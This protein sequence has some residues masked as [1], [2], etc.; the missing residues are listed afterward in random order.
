MLEHI[1]EYIFYKKINLDEFLI[2]LMLSFFPFITV[3]IK[4]GCYAYI[5]FIFLIIIALVSLPTIFKNIKTKIGKSDIYLLLFIIFVFISTLLSYDKKTAIWGLYGVKAI[6]AKGNVGDNTLVVINTLRLTGFVTYIACIISYLLSSKI[7][8]S[9]KFIKYMIYACAAISIIAIMQHFGIDIITQ[10]F[11]PDNFYAYGTLGN[12]NFLGTYT[13][14]ILPASIFVAL[15]Y[16]KKKYFVVACIIYAGMLVSLTRGVWLSFFITLLIIISYT[17]KHKELRY[18]LLNIIISFVI[19]TAVLMPTQNGIIY[20][21]ALSI[22]DNIASG[23]L[24]EGSSGSGRIAI[25]KDIKKLIP[26]YWTFGIG[27]DNLVFAG[28]KFNNSVVDKAHNIYL[29]M[30]VT[31]GLFTLLSFFLFISSFLKKIIDDSDFMY[32][33]MIFTYLVQGFFNIDTIMVMPLFWI[34]LGLSKGHTRN[35]N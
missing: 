30:L 10:K 6:I 19:V 25:W 22:P 3:P 24:M 21:R 26:R 8:D 7:K 14:F 13:V 16:R 31:M 23:I 34:I 35:E 9:E 15:K 4:D 20:K 5:R 18:G 1:K 28:I 2:F 29:E 33:L 11:N 27:P 12:S 32:F 17:L